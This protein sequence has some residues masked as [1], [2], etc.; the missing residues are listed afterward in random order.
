MLYFI[1]KLATF[2]V[3]FIFNF[4]KSEY[5]PICLTKAAQ[6]IT[7]STIFPNVSNCSSDKPKFL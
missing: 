7:K 5:L 2:S 4:S 6:W 3:P 1:Q